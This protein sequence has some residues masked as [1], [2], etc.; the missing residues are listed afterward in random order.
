MSMRADAVCD[1][2]VR[3]RLN[4]EAHGNSFPS[5]IYDGDGT[6]L[7]G[8]LVPYIVRISAVLLSRQAGLCHIYFPIYC[9]PYLHPLQLR[10]LSS[11]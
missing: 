6:K 4:H 3:V 1:A 7:W 8:L 9:Q 10:A 5:F 11:S 2:D